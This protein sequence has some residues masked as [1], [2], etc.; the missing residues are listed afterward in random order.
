MADDADAL[1]EE[2]LSVIEDDKQQVEVTDDD[3]I[4]ELLSW[5]P[6][7]RKE[8]MESILCGDDTENEYDVGI[9]E[10]LGLRPRSPVQ[11]TGDIV[12]N[13]SPLRS[14]AKKRAAPAAAAPAKKQKRGRKELPA[15]CKLKYGWNPSGSSFMGC[16]RVQ[17]KN[18]LVHERW[19]KEEVCSK[20]DSMIKKWKWTEDDESKHSNKNVPRWL[21]KVIL[22]HGTEWFRHQDVV[23]N[24][25][26]YTNR[27][28]PREGTTKFYPPYD[29]MCCGYEVRR[30]PF[31]EMSDNREQMRLSP[32]FVERLRGAN[33]MK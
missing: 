1:V 17:A 24:K 3:T 14:P 7:G 16:V 12:L 30:C 31:T 32:V 2:L 18:D 21:R 4:D 29:A 9:E 28:R 33:V 27:R 19:T 22:E 20:L 26:D 10:M 11:M 23:I 15:T 25:M 5:I 13:G 8:D 6:E